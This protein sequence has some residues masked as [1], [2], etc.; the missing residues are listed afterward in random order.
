VLAFTEAGSVQLLGALLVFCGVMV[1]ATASV[2][3]ARYTRSTNRE[4]RYRNGGGVDGTLAER[5]DAR[6]ER[7][8]TRFDRIE[9][10]STRVAEKA[11]ELAKRIES[12]VVRIDR[13]ERNV[14]D[15]RRRA[16]AFFDR[17]YLKE[18]D[19]E[20]RHVLERRE[21]RERERDRWGD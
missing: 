2:V 18:K 17:F 6:F 7:I 13:T 12:N 11:D 20:A 8:E 3:A 9:E 1:T 10:R 16:F 21:D 4:V 5:L 19:D 14:R 15:M